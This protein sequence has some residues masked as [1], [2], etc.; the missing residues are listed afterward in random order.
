MDKGF[1][2]NNDKDYHEA[3]IAIYELMNKGEA[4]LQPDEIAR[5]KVMTVATEKYED[6]V[7]NLKPI[8]Q[9]NTLSEVIEFFMYENRLT[10]AKLADK[11]GVDRPKLSQIMNGK[12]KPDVPFLKALYSKLNID[13][14]VILEHV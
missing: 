6:E 12:R 10:R 4:A 8:R 5:L 11:L 13:P 14:K 2:I 1:A 3:M 9:P 7:L